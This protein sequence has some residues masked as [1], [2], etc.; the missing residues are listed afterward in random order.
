VV[1]MGMRTV[2]RIA[3]GILGIGQS[4]VCFKPEAVP[5]ISEALTR[6]DVRSLIKEGSIYSISPR[7]VSRLRG[8]EK[9]AQRQK[10]RRKGAG[11]R[12]GSAGARSGKKEAWMAKVRAQRKY[13]RILVSENRLAPDVARKVYLMVKGNAFRGVRALEAYLQNNKMLKEAKEGNR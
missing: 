11:S 5:K 9:K 4:K 2:R 3:A 10:G 1:Q 13:L 7:G 12:R 8:R 6:E